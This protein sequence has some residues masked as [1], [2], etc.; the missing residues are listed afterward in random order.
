MS[1][2]ASFAL[3]ALFTIPLHAQEKVAPE[4]FDIAT[5][6]KLD[7]IVKKYFSHNDYLKLSELIRDKLLERIPRKVQAEHIKEALV[8]KIGGDQAQALVN[9]LRNVFEIE[10]PGLFARVKDA[11]A[12]FFNVQ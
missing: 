12:Q 8:K 9:E 5:A 4:E 7:F 10:K 11:F 3:F 2:V 1:F 6:G